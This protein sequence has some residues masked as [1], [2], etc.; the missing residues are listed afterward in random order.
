MK[1]I[2]SVQHSHDNVSTINILLILK[3]KSIRKIKNVKLMDGMANVVEK[4]SQFGSIVPAR[5][6]RSLNGTKMMWDI[7]I[8]EPGA[9]IAISYTVK[10]KAKIIGKL[11]VPVALVKYMK[12][13]RRIVVKSNKIKIF[14]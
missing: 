12:S 1:R 6:V 3:N 8:I 10:C 4:P 5:I 14:R 7:P 2:T 11:Q 9:E 13:G